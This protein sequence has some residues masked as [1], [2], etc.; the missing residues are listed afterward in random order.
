MG[1]DPSA[2]YGRQ[3]APEDTNVLL[4][5]HAREFA[6]KAGIDLEKYPAA[7]D[8]I[9]LAI[10]QTKLKVDK[11]ESASKAS[12]GATLYQ[13]QEVQQQQQQQQQQQMTQQ[14]AFNYIT[15]QG[16]QS[17]SEVNYANGMLAMGRRTALLPDPLWQANCLLSGRL[18]GRTTPTEHMLITF[19]QNTL[20]TNQQ[21][22]SLSS[23]SCLANR[24]L[25]YT[26]ANPTTFTQNTFSSN[27]QTESLSSPSCLANRLLTYIPANPTTFTENTFSSNRQTV[28]LSSLCQAEGSLTGNKG[29]FFPNLYLLPNFYQ[30]TTTSMP[31]EDLKPATF[32][33]A[34]LDKATGRRDYR[35]IS[36]E[37]A[38]VY[39]AQLQ[40]ENRHGEVEQ[41]GFIFTANGA[42]HQT[43]RSTSGLSP[44][45]VEEWQKSDEFH[46][47]LAQIGLIDGRRIEE[48][49]QWKLVHEHPK[50]L[51][52]L[53]T[54][55]KNHLLRSDTTFQQNVSSLLDMLKRPNPQL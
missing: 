40:N 53:K 21:T 47:I 16:D 49:W 25:T 3:T 7:R 36:T 45:A 33:M 23:P 43:D 22:V 24:L 26:P 11:M 14:R 2:K 37:D 15:P 55:W 31:G 18:V 38:R 51:D 30:T 27:R 5:N 52:D 6:E 17:I 50:A 46:Q 9:A 12:L 35:V 28:S 32:I 4:W 8:R 34:T 44:A 10:K 39:S 13:Q 29:W 42:I 20:S 1:N 41:T 19:T 54:I 48:Q